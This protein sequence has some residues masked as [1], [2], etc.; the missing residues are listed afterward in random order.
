MKR[1]TV[2]LP[3]LILLGLGAAYGGGDGRED[4]FRQLEEILPTPNTYRTASGAPGHEYWQQRADYVIDVELDET[5]HRLTGS[6]TITYTNNSPDALDYLWLHLEQ[7]I[8]RPDSIGAHIASNTAIGM[9]EAFGVGITID[10]LTLGTIDLPFEVSF[11]ET[12][13]HLYDLGNCCVTADS[14]RDIGGFRAGPLYCTT[15]SFTDGLRIDNCLLA[16]R[17]RGCRFCRIG[18]DPIALTRP[19]K[20]NQLDRRRGYIE[21]QQWLRFFSEKHVFFLLGR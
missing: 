4:K 11:R 14:D 6:E 9:S 15:N 16:N 7:N 10:S 1:I 12:R 13:W 17:T 2:A 20:L 19:G 21:T 8:F 5:E 3:F 18:L